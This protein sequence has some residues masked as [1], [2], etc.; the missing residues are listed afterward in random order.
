MV[1]CGRAHDPTRERG[2]IGKLAAALA[3]QDWSFEFACRRSSSRSHAG[4]EGAGL[5]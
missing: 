3:R 1:V 5:I 4:Q 2:W